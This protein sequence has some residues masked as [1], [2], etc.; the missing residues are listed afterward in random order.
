MVFDA[1]DML[2]GLFDAPAVPVAAAQGPE[3][4]APL[5]D[6]AAEPAAGRYADWVQAP[7]TRGRLG[8]QAPEAPVPWVAWED[9]PEWPAEPAPTAEALP[10]APLTQRVLLTPATPASARTG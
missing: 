4:A 7:D 3:P 9:L 5:L 10:S 6:T 2:A 8:L 1:A